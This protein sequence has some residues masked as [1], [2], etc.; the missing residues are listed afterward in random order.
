MKWEEAT[1]GR[2]AERSVA[3]EMEFA[4]MLTP[5]EAIRKASAQKK[6]AALPPLL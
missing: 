4:E 3:T 1:L 6:A 2:R 5:I